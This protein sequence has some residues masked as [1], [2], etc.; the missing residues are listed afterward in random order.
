[1]FPIWPKLLLA[2]K[3]ASVRFGWAQFIAKNEKKTNQKL[4]HNQTIARTTCIMCAECT[5]RKTTKTATTTT[6][7][8]HLL[9][10]QEKETK[11]QVWWLVWLQW[12]SKY[13]S[14][15][16]DRRLDCFCFFFFFAI[17]G[18][19]DSNIVRVVVA[20]VVVLRGVFF[21]VSI[22]NI[23]CFPVLHCQYV[24]VLENWYENKV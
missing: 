22:V 24:R 2:S 1:M 17:V 23:F 16:V 13:I 18:Y 12:L 10:Y 21:C 15:M 5:W 9:N 4:F 19:F 6:T 7:I 3:F 14:A 20:V 11:F 8:T